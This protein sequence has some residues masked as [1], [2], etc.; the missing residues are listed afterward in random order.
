MASISPPVAPIEAIVSPAPRRT[1]YRRHVVGILFLGYAFSAIDAR[2]LTLLVGPIKARLGL[3]DFDISLLQGFAFAL[4]YSIAAMP[5]GRY[6]DGASRRTP[7]MVVGVLF[8]SV[9]TM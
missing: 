5:I 6:V 4:L 7:L 3:S 1:A 2:V 9:M 8:W